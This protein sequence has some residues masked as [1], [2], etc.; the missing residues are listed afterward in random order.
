MA[1][2]KDIIK[3]SSLIVDNQPINKTNFVPD[4]VE[5]INEVS[6]Y[7]PIKIS[8]FK[9]TIIVVDEI[10]E[11]GNY[12]PETC[13][14]AYD[15]NKVSMYVDQQKNETLM[16][17]YYTIEEI[18]EILSGKT[19]V[20]SVYTKDETYNKNEVYNLEEIDFLLKLKANKVDV[21]SKIDMNTLLDLK[22]NKNEVYDKN[23]IDEILGSYYTKIEIDTILE[24]K[25]DIED[26]IAISGQVLTNIEDIE[27]LETNKQDKLIAG[28]NITISGNVISADLNVDL[29]DYLKIVDASNTYET[30]INVNLLTNIVSANTED[31]SDLYINKADVTDLL[32]VSGQTLFNAENIENLQLNK[33]DKLLAG[34]NIVISGNVISADLNDYLTTDEASNTY[35]TIENVNSLSD[36]VSGHTGDIESLEA[37]KA[38]TSHTHTKSEVGLSNV[39]NTSDANKPISNATQTALNNKADTLHTH[40]ATAISTVPPSGYTSTDVSGI[41]TEIV[42][43]KQDKNKTLNDVIVNNFIDSSTYTEFA[44]EASITIPG[45]LSTHFANVAYSLAD[46]YSTNFAP[47][48]ETYDGGVKIYSKT[49]TEIIIK[50][51][52]VFL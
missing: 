36:I 42:N 7:K 21:Y 32:L 23:E 34:E 44:Y 8:D 4:T 52:I 35:E 48:C 13:Q 38:N 28:D 26:V 1:E 3:L 27:Y 10:Q 37:N 49:N 40:P 47:I 43:K 14:N 50:T 31:I 6:N 16:S 17:N 39:D 45:V 25:A 19:N 30:I 22:A 12:Q 33:Q 46:V 51:I 24:N 2:N 11:N 29:N 15:P 9:K 18:E 5:L 20:D 41:V